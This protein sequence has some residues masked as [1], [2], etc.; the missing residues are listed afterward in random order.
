MGFEE[1]LLAVALTTALSN[2]VIPRNLGWVT[3][4][5]GMM[6]IIRS[7]VRMPDVGY[8]SR[9]RAPGG[10]RP[11]GPIA[12][13][14]PDLAVEVLSD[15]NTRAEMARKRREY[16]EGGTRLVWEVDPVA[17]TV[18]VYTSAEAP[19]AVVG[20]QET[21][22]GGNVLPGFTLRLADLFRCLDD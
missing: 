22:D 2:F 14:S 11:R 4:A 15:S 7:Q 19:T 9:E 13:I 16:F 3:G 21:L 10:R 8:V 1:S 20:E 6:R 5:D 18:A 17:R 12:D